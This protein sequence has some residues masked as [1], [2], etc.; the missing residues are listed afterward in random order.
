MQWAAMA[1]SLPIFGGKSRVEERRVISGMV[2]RFREGGRCR[3]CRLRALRPPTGSTRGA[4]GARGRTFSSPFRTATIRRR[5]AS[6]TVPPVAPTARLRA[7]RRSGVGAANGAG[8]LSASCALGS[9][10]AARTGC[11]RDYRA[12]RF[13]AVAPTGAMTPGGPFSIHRVGFMVKPV[14]PITAH[15][16]N[17]RPRLARNQSPGR[18]V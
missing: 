18:L 3:A 10:T 11:R 15:R 14:S 6:A 16:L 4:N 13:H 8:N 9:R 1:P 7:T 12:D 2:H 17:R 5:S